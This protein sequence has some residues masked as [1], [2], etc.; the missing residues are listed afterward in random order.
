LALQRLAEAEALASDFKH[1]FLITRLLMRREA[2]SSSAIE[3]TSSTL[4]ELLQAEETE[5]GEESAATKQVRSYAQTL[6]RWMPTAT[7]KGPAIFTDNLLKNLHQAVME[8]DDSYQDVPGEIRTVPVWIGGRDIAYST[9]NPPPPAKVRECLDQTLDYL[10]CEGEQ[11]QTQGLLTRMAIGHAHFEGVHPYRDGN[12]RT[13]RLLLP[14]MMA[15]EGRLPLYLSPYIE[16]HKGAYG[17]ALKAAQQ[18]LDWPEMVGF[19]AE[20]VIGTV[21][22]LKETISALAK[23]K[24]IWLTR[25]Q[26]RKGSSAM[27]TLSILTSYPVITVGRLADTLDVSYPAANRCVDQLVECGI[28]TE[29]TGYSRNRLFVAK[30][31]LS[32][33]NR[34]FGEEP[35]VP[36]ALARK[37]AKR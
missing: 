35:I 33:I 18:R 17:A 31:V 3:G 27:M 13:G 26:F 37:K 32:I 24:E 29:R 25:R 14:L 30:E 21:D 15:A 22:E 19:I 4:D 16:A 7:K 6:E 8:D 10:R 34:P 36:Q 20:S 11:V 2:V 23:M 5:D 9:Y 1:K 28:L 12:G